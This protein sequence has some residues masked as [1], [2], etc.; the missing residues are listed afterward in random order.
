MKIAPYGVWME[1]ERKGIATAAVIGERRP[2]F[3][4]PSEW[5]FAS[6]SLFKAVSPFTFE[7]WHVVDFPSCV[8]H[9][10]LPF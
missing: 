9:E 10:L 8:A 5:L 3:K 4:L 6:R 2:G 7:S 1:K